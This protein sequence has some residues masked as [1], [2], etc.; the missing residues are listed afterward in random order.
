LFIRLTLVKA[1]GTIEPTIDIGYKHITRMLRVNASSESPAY[2]S[3]TH[4]F[5]ADGRE[6]CDR[7]LETREEIL[8]LV[9]SNE[10]A[11]HKRLREGV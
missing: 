1:D 2:T 5:A 3:L 4:F 9:V 6:C 10:V 11:I 8:A 7:V